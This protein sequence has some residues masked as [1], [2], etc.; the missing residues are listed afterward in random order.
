MEES[1]A[2]ES[3]YMET[4]LRGKWK[5]IRKYRKVKLI[6]KMSMAT[7]TLKGVLYS[8]PQWPSSCLRILVWESASWWEILFLMR[9]NWWSRNVIGNTAILLIK[10]ID[11]IIDFKRYSIIMAVVSI[12]CI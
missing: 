3:K 7:W 6:G 8:F 2:G 9:E 4:R 11:I 5:S 1:H 12:I 10:L